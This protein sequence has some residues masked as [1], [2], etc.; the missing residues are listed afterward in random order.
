MKYL[1]S[2][3]FLFICSILTAQQTKEFGDITF[4]DFSVTPFDSVASS[5]VLFNKEEYGGS[6][7]PYIDHHIRVKIIN[8]N[9]FDLWGD[10]RLGD[11]YE[12]ISK[13]KAATYYLKDGKIV[14]NLIEKENI[15]SDYKSNNEKILSLTNLQEGCV[16]ELSYRSETTY[17]TMP[18]WIIQDEV[19]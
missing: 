15:Y 7:V 13:L 5:V 1:Y 12:S 4:E 19:K 6:F 11:R 9:G 3:A 18:W 10:F 8:R 14:R 16:I 17:H 2:I